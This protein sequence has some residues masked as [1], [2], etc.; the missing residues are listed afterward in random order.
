MPPQLKLAPHPVVEA[1]ERFT[2][3][4]FWVVREEAEVM[5]VLSPPMPHSPRPL[6][7]R[8]VRTP[9]DFGWVLVQE[10]NEAFL[11]SD[12]TLNVSLVGR[13]SVAVVVFSEVAG[14]HNRPL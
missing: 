1:E 13:D 6:L 14:Q 12:E 7:H 2:E 3:H 5:Y 4:F 11:A 9:D 8:E 10:T